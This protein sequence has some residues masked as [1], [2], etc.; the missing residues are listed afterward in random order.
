MERTIESYLAIKGEKKLKNKLVASTL[1][2]VTNQGILKVIGMHFD[3]ERPTP[4]GYGA[5][6]V[7]VLPMIKD[8]HQLYNFRPKDDGDAELSFLHLWTTNRLVSNNGKQ[9]RTINSRE[10][11]RQPVSRTNFIGKITA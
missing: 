10:K 4:S 3:A 9:E 7:S 8:E 2:T 11:F 5:V 1:S 6:T